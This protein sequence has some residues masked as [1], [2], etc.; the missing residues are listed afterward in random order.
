MIKIA[1]SETNSDYDLPDYFDPVEE[2]KNLTDKEKLESI[3]YK[4]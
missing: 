4:M 3:D 2:F 1:H